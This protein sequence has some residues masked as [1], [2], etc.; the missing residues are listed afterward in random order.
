MERK[1]WMTLMLPRDTLARFVL[2]PQWVSAALPA[3]STI[4]TTLYAFRLHPVGAV[5]LVR[6]GV[7]YLVSLQFIVSLK[8]QRE[9]KK[10][11][12]NCNFHLVVILASVYKCSVMWLAIFKGGTV[13]SLSACLHHHKAQCVVAAPHPPPP[14]P[15]TPSLVFFFVFF[16]A[17]ADT[18]QLGLLTLTGVRNR[19]LRSNRWDARRSPCHPLAFFFFFTHAFNPLPLPPPSPPSPSFETTI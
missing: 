3:A 9:E 11:R 14:P 5:G 2:F 10:N 6:T 19:H 18:R 13:G 4:K 15:P 16:A 12:G 8:K 7:F 17:H 1:V